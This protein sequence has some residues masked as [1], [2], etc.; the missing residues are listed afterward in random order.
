LVRLVWFYSDQEADDEQE[1]NSIKQSL[2]RDLIKSSL[3]ELNSSL[4]ES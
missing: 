1:S 4:I 2:S 3:T